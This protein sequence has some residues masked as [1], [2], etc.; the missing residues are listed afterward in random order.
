MTY[1]DLHFRTEN[2]FFEQEAFDAARYFLS[3]AHDLT[4]DKEIEK[5]IDSLPQSQASE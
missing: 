2:T 4:G 5:M 1:S 3:I